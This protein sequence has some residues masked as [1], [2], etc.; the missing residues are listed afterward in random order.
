MVPSFSDSLYTWAPAGAPVTRTVATANPMR[1]KRV[2]PYGKGPAV[3]PSRT[4]ND[5]GNYTNVNKSSR[6]GERLDLGPGRGGL[7][8]EPQH[9]RNGIRQVDRHFLSHL[10][11]NILDEVL[12]VSLGQEHGADPRA[13]RRQDLLLDP[14]DR[15]HPPGKA[16]LARHGEAGSHAA[17]GEQRHERGRHRDAGRGPVLR[18]GTGGDVGVGVPCFPEIRR[19][20]EV[21]PRRTEPPRGRPPRRLS[22]GPPRNGQQQAAPC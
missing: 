16:H 9:V 6:Y 1:P 18:N 15:K 3:S 2:M 21:V 4:E 12:L 10:Q 19:E 11:R 22:Y 13:V 17:A 7:E 5:P 8:G 20:P 14:T